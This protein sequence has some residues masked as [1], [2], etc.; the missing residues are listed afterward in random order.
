MATRVY[1]QRIGVTRGYCISTISGREEFLLPWAPN[2]PPI[3]ALLEPRK[4][5]PH[6][7]ATGLALRVSRACS[8]CLCPS[9]GHQTQAGRGGANGLGVGPAHL[10]GQ[11]VLTCKS[12]SG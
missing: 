2:L 7:A 9:V 1:P 11:G 10:Q 8:L 5:L 4:F 6:P 12:V 3:P